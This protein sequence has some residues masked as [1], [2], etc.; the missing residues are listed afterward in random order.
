L[1]SR[2]TV[3]TLQRLAKG[4]WIAEEAAKELSEAY[5]FLRRIENR[6]QMVADQQT[7]IIPADPAELDRVAALSG[8]ADADAFGDALL[9]RF[10]R[11]EIHYGALF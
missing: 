4:G 8:Y 7:H 10:K 6:L 9:A 1:R 3:E 2:S 11:V 5:L